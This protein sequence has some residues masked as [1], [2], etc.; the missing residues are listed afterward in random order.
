MSD[1]RLK[2]GVSSVARPTGDDLWTPLRGTR[3]GAMFTA[4]W[5]LAHALEGRCFGCNSG[6]GTTAVTHNA[7]YTAAKPDMLITV[8]SGTTII[9]VFIETSM[10]NTGTAAITTIV[11]CASSVYDAATTD[12][13]LVIYNMRIQTSAPRTSSCQAVATVTAA[14]TTPLSGNFIEFWRGTAGFVEAAFTGNTSP[15]NEQISRASWNIKEAAV[16]PVIVG[17][18]SLNIYMSC[19]A[20]VGFITAIWVE[21]PSTAIV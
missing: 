14:G 2:T 8:P 21:I 1:L 11:A 4:D 15:K 13:D 9:P 12:D 18:G 17:E 7:T 10:E 16:P 6:T 5:V 3:D 20:S 19:T